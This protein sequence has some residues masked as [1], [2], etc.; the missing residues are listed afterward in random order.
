MVAQLRLSRKPPTC[1]CQKK[2]G[3]PGASCSL[4]FFHLPA[5]RGPDC[6][7]AGA[8][9]GPG[10]WHGG[11]AGQLLWLR[12][13]SLCWVRRWRT[14]GHFLKL[15]R[16][17]FFFLFVDRGTFPEEGRGERAAVNALCKYRSEVVFYPVKSSASS[18]FFFFFLVNSRV[19]S[20]TCWALS[21]WF[22]FSGPLLRLRLRPGI[23]A[24]IFAF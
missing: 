17:F 8:R 15:L 23:L 16:C 13:R 18:F 14:R 9:P 22:C 12:R 19:K 20:W 3:V 4:C 11:S 10:R 5:A 1:F 2:G 6:G 7:C 24:G 21:L